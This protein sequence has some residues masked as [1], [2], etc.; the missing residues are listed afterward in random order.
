MYLD[1]ISDKLDF[2]VDME[3]VVTS[4]KNE[5]YYNELY[6]LNW[7]IEKINEGSFKY[8][9]KLAKK[10]YELSSQINQ[11]IEKPF[12]MKYTTLNSTQLNENL[13]R[14]SQKLNKII[15]SLK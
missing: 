4:K 10:I 7:I 15:E 11:V 13:V 8:D 9:N 14:L 12:D 2:L 1:K 5:L 3:N 6:S